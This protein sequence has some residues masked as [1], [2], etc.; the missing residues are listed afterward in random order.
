MVSRQSGFSLIE[1]LIALVVIAIILAMAV[2][3]L[4]PTT[5]AANE[6]TAVSHMRNLGTAQELYRNRNGVYADSHEVLVNQGFIGVDSAKRLGYQYVVRRNGT[7]WEATGEPIVPGVTGDRRFFISGS[8]HVVRYSR[9]GIPSITSAA[10]G[11]S[12]SA[13]AS[14]RTPPGIDCRRR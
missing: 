13:P 4:L 1:I 10:V 6:A 5:K 7:T 2:P 8:D 3:N 12:R 14:R 9:D 11:G